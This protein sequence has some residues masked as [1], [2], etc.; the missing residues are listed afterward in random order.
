MLY[1]KEEEGFFVRQGWGGLVSIGL[2]VAIG[3]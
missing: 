1:P 3:F 2:L